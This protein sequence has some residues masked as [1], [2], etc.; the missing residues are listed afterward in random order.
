MVHLQR[1]VGERSENRCFL[2]SASYPDLDT[3]PA[4]YLDVSLALHWFKFT[5]ASFLENWVLPNF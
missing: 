2:K 1:R 5:G 4:F 3:S